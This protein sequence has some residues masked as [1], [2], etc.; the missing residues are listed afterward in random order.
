MKYTYAKEQVPVFQVSVVLTHI[1]S[2]VVCTL[3]R[4]VSS[5]FIVWNS[6]TIVTCSHHLL[7]GILVKPIITLQFGIR[8]YVQPVTVFIFQYSQV[9]KFTTTWTLWLRLCEYHYARGYQHE[10]LI[11]NFWVPVM[12]TFPSPRVKGWA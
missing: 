3:W 12:C 4:W 7:G 6:D 8:R 11:V 5:L 1:W 10:L 2:P 9:L